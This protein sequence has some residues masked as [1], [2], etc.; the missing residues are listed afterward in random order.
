MT[1]IRGRGRPCIERTSKNPWR[2]SPSLEFSHD[3]TLVN[4]LAIEPL[5]AEYTEENLQRILKMVFEAQAL[6]SDGLHKKLLKA[7]LPNV[8]CGK[9]YIEYYNFC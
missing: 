5:V 4:L 9:F 1:S 6:P 7:K 3:K 2:S 8:Y